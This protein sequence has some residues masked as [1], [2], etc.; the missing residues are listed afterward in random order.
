MGD[1]GGGDRIAGGHPG[2]VQHGIA[3]LSFVAKRAVQLHNHVETVH[4]PG[5]RERGHDQ[6]E[7]GHRHRG[8]ADRGVG[9]SQNEIL[10]RVHGQQRVRGHRAGWRRVGRHIQTVHA[11]RAERHTETLRRGGRRDRNVRQGI[12]VRSRREQS[13]QVQ[14]V[15]ESGGLAAELAKSVRRPA[16]MGNVRT[17]GLVVIAHTKMGTQQPSHVATATPRSRAIRLFPVDQ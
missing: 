2:V 15:V 16:W 9:P 13:G 7:T 8:V 17:D 10:D 3:G 5:R 12:V 14:G 1:G 4:G 6:M 11:G